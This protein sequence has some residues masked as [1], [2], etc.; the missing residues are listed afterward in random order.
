MLERE[1]VLKVK[2]KQ[3]RP[4]KIEKEQEQRLAL[5]FVLCLSVVINDSNLINQS[6]Y[7]SVQTLFGPDSC[8]L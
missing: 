1:K 5:C 7:F 6:C 8:L 2:G 4:R 3:G